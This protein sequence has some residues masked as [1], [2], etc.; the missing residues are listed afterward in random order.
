MELHQTEHFLA[1]FKAAER[2]VT[3]VQLQLEFFRPAQRL[4][5]A[6]L[7][8]GVVLVE[9]ARHVAGVIGQREQSLLDVMKVGLASK[10]RELGTFGAGRRWS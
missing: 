5:P 7:L 2:K 8:H 4:H 3:V 9:A 6:E 1:R 10:C